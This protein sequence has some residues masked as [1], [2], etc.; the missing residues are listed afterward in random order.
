MDERKEGVPNLDEYV[1]V[2]I[3]NPVKNNI[4]YLYVGQN[5]IINKEG[6]KIIEISIPTNAKHITK[7][8]LKDNNKI[9]IRNIVVLFGYA[10]DKDTLGLVQTLSIFTH[11]VGFLLNGRISMLSHSLSKQE[12][13]FS[14]DNI[15]KELYL[16]RKSS[17]VELQ[18]EVK[19]SLITT[20]KIVRKITFH[21]LR[22]V[23]N[24]K[25]KEK[26]KG[27]SDLYGI[28]NEEAIEKLVDKL[29]FLIW[30]HSI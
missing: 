10:V 16:L 23:D 6:T 28:K 24:E 22:N 1:F 25:L 14:K 5:L 30:Y 21:S 18:N 27:I 12:I 8:T 20:S 15:L 3:I 29:S 26:L 19:I 7:I 13:I 2:P 17:K 11:A 4:D 9:K